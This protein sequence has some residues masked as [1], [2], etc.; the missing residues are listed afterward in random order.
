MHVWMTGCQSRYVLW[1]NLLV[2][3]ILEIYMKAVQFALAFALAGAMGSAAA[4]TTITYIG[5]Q[6]LG[7]LVG[8]TAIINNTINGYGTAGTSGGTYLG[9]L[10][11][12]PVPETKSYALLLAG[13]GLVVMKVG[14]A[15]RRLL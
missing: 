14:R 7:D 9:T 11:A 5:T 10:S 1:M 6:Y 4:T 3:I 8:Q 13:L 12:A 2:H 15:R